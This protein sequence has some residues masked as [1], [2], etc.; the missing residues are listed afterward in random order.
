MAVF[1]TFLNKKRQIKSLS[2]K[3]AWLKRVDALGLSLLSFN[4]GER[5]VPI[6]HVNGV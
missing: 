4:F 1:E 3:C 5:R 6:L 2:Y